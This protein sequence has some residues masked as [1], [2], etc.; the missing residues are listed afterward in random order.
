MNLQALLDITGGQLLNTPPISEFH[1]IIFDSKK[2]Q[3]GDLFISEDTEAISFALDQGAYGILTT[4]KLDKR[5]LESAWILCDSLQKALIKLLRFFILEK[6]IPV[7][8]GEKSV[9]EI[10]AQIHTSKS[11]LLESENLSLLLQRVIQSEHDDILLLH[12]ES[13]VQDIAPGFK[14]LDN[15][16]DTYPKIL[17]E[18][19]F[20]TSFVWKEIYYDH[21]PIPALFLTSFQK[22]ILFL[23]QHQLPY[24]SHKAGLLSAFYPQF[25]NSRLE[26]LPFGKGERALIFCEDV[27]RASQIISFCKETVPWAHFLFLFQSGYK[28]MFLT[29]NETTYYEKDEDVFAILSGTKFNYAL[30]FGFDRKKQTFLPSRGKQASSL[31]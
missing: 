12:T 25:V 15:V 10:I 27:T 18:T 16:I 3:R 5:D 22:A 21:L 29:E 26:P 14:H 30:I 2:V 19:L 20:T 8:L 31:F 17:K 28:N 24:K 6:A 4:L 11:I 1:Q 23:D 7:L 13:L 9:C